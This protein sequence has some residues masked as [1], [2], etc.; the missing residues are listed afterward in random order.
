MLWPGPENPHIVYGRGGTPTFMSPPDRH[1]L[2]SSYGSDIWALGV[3]MY[4]WITLGVCALFSP[5]FFQLTW[6]VKLGLRGVCSRWDLGGEQETS[7]I[8]CGSRFFSARTSSFPSCCVRCSHRT[9]R[10]S[11][12]PC[13]TGSRTGTRFS[14]TP[15]GGLHNCFKTYIL[16]SVLPRGRS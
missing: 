3:T 13:H 2:P 5:F 15:C 12:G 9:Q 7:V 10:L 8:G 6:L 4:E 11:P 16:D 1:H 14:A